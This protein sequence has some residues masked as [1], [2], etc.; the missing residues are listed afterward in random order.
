M[1]KE[2]LNQVPGCNDIPLP[3]VKLNRWVLLTGVILAL[4][5]QQ[6]V[7]TTFLFAIILPAVLFGQK[8]SLIFQLGTRLFAAQC[9]RAELEDRRVQRFNNSI[10]L[11]LL[12]I[13]Q[14]FFLTGLNLGGWIFSVI[15]AIAAGV[16]LL[17]FCFGCF[18]YFQFKLNR[19]RLL[20][21]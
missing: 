15:V 13:A 2:Y 12:G 5:L 17:G 10:A 7:I 9:A 1:T 4:L 21:S 20:G 3:V 11:I 16:A 14:I 8:G 6:P 19:Y 18:L